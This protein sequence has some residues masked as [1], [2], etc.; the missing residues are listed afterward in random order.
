MSREL[1]RHPVAAK[2]GKQRALRPTIR[3]PRVLAA[4][5]DSGRRGLAALRPAWA[6]DVFSELRKVQWP[7][8]QEAWN[9][10]IVVIVV[11]IFFGIGLWI[12]DLTFQW[13]LQHTVLR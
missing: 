10:T 2:P 4:G 5:R 3:T 12:T 9:L 11:C 8:P 13:L 6:E 1:R 7:T